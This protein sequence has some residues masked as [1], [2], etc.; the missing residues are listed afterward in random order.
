MQNDR[1]LLTTYGPLLTSNTL[2]VHQP[3]EPDTSTL[4]VSFTGNPF[5]SPQDNP[6]ATPRVITGGGGGGGVLLMFNGNDELG[7][8]F[9]SP[10]GS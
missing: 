2:C 10:R 1:I 9:A 8:P 4:S 7:N 5:D 3:Q 6:F